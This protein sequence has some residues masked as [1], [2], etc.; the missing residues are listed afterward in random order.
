MKQCQLLTVTAQLNGGQVIAV[1]GRDAWASLELKS[2]NDTGCTP[3][4]Q[5]GPRWSGYLHKLRKTGIIVETIREAHGGQFSGQHARACAAEPDYHPRKERLQVV[6]AFAGLQ[7]VAGGVSAPPALTPQ[8]TL[9][10]I[11]DGFLCL[12]SEEARHGETTKA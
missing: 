2:A 11:T 9:R 4:H 1:R 10:T 7:I 5:P 3:I 6:K 8:P 12:Q